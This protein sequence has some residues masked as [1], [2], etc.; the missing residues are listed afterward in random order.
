MRKSLKY[1]ILGRGCAAIRI[2]VS[3]VLIALSGF[4]QDSG[5][6]LTVR[7]ANDASRF[8]VGEMIPIELAFISK[9][10]GAYEMDTRMYDRSGRLDEE[11]FHVSP[12]GRDP[13]YNHYNGGLYGG[14]MGGG[15][16]RTYQL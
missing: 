9:T 3:I 10:P 7:F 12:P 15:L 14:F 1:K 8:H 2:K 16:G 13:L 4:A 5:V 11:Q 6:S